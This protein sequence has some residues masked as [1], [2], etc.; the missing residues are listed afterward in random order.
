MA[1][2]L[3][4]LSARELLNELK[5]MERAIGREQ[6]I[7]R[8]GPRRIDFDISVFGDQIIAEHDLTVPH[9]GVPRRNFVLYPLADIAPT[10]LIPRFGR[11]SELLESVDQTGIEP[12]T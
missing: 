2:L 10:L 8:W 11:V 9:S 5:S 12:V 4:Q 3:T 7:V 6:P 1:G